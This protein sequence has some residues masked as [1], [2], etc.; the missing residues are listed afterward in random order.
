MRAAPALWTHPR[1]SPTGSPHV[2][3]VAKER[4]PPPPSLVAEHQ[5]AAAAG[6]GSV[7][8][9]GIPSCYEQLGHHPL[10]RCPIELSFDAPQ[11]NCTILPLTPHAL[12]AVTGQV[13]HATGWL[14]P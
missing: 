2:G 10:D 9:V 12:D 14:S 4:C 7:V 8:I 3:E 13:E 1:T 6:F 5:R 11:E